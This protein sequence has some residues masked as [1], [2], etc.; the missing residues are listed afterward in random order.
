MRRTFQLFFELRKNSLEGRA[1]A[2]GVVR[3]S[4]NGSSHQ[5]QQLRN[6]LWSEM[7][8]LGAV[9]MTVNMLVDVSF[10]ACA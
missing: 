2:V 6:A 7:A 8:V 5:R 4:R 1:T 9:Q 10:A 3:S